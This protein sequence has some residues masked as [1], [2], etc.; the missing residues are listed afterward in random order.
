MKPSPL[1]QRT[2]RRRRSPSGRRRSATR[3]RARDGVSR[4]AGAET[5]RSATAAWRLQSSVFWASRRL[6]CSARQQRLL[7]TEW[8]RRAA[9]MRL[10]CTAAACRSILCTSLLRHAKRAHRGLV[11]VA[12]PFVCVE[13]SHHFR[14]RRTISAE[15]LQEL[16][17]AVASS[18]I[19]VGVSARITIDDAIRLTVLI[20][21]YIQF[22]WQHARMRRTSTVQLGH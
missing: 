18:R 4:A 7:K 19:M 11:I 15:V 9:D 20:H 12:S 22:T 2:P 21:T 3:A 14:H 10:A 1:Q 5:A 8:W 16:G 17:K 6:Q 13:C